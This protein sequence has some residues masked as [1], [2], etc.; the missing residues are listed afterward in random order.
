VLDRTFEE[1]GITAILPGERAVNW[2]CDPIP[3]VMSAAEFAALESGLAQRAQLM[4]HILADLYG[5]QTILAEGLIPPDLVYGNP[6]FL[7]PCRTVDG[8]RTDRYLSFYA[9]DMLRGPDCAGKPPNSLAH[10]AG[11]VPVPAHPATAPVS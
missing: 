4:E 11:T 10:R 8:K 2:R 7:R 1:E 9:A 6:S 3:L 5:A